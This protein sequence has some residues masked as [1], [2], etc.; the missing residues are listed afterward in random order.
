MAPF[1]F[2]WV[3]SALGLKNGCYTGTSITTFH[4]VLPILQWHV[5]YSLDITP[6]SFISP[7]LLHVFACS[8]ISP[9]L[10]HVR[11]ICMNLQLRYNYLQFTPPP[12]P[13]WLWRTREWL[14]L[15]VPP[16]IWSLATYMYWPA[17]YRPS[18]WLRGGRLISSWWWCENC[19]T[20]LT[21][22]TLRLHW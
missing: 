8:F 21:A 17:I 5:P 16:Y 14:E 19:I 10:L 13:L 2:L 4:S 1:V 18:D 6:P 9:S 15:T 22:H 11:C 12:W 7:S 20:F 3:P